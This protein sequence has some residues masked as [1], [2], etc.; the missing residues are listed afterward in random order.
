[1]PACS[2]LL[3]LHVVM[4]HLGTGIPT[5][6]QHPPSLS[7]SLQGSLG[8]LAQHTAHQTHISFSKWAEQV[9]RRRGTRCLEV[10]GPLKLFMP[11]EHLLESCSPPSLV[12]IWFFG[13]QLHLSWQEAP[14]EPHFVAK[15]KDPYHPGTEATK[16]ANPFTM[17]FIF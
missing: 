4:I 1:M 11:R 14:S 7:S 9:G 15:A 10:E 2:S 6:S 12:L 17:S 16:G 8:G 13:H 3:G 5:H